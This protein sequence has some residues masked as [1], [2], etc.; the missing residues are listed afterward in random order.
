[1]YQVSSDPGVGE[2]EFETFQE[3]IAK[4]YKLASQ[5]N[6]AH[7]S[8]WCGNVKV[9][10]CFPDNW[11]TPWISEEIRFKEKIFNVREFVKTLGTP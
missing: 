4:A 9:A 6:W 10:V 3:A 7:V 8:V 5:S 2:G 1:M 11:T